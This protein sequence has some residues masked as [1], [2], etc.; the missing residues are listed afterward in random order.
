MLGDLFAGRL[1]LEKGLNALKCFG[2]MFKRFGFRS[3][4]PGYIRP[5]MLRFIGVI[6]ISIYICVLCVYIYIWG[7]ISIVEKTIQ[8]TFARQYWMIATSF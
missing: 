8:A 5:F 6:Y 1:V 3:K 2:Y 7:H 4:P